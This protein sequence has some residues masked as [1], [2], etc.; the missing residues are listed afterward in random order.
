MIAAVFDTEN[1]GL[2]ANTGRKLDKQPRLFEFY[3]NLITD[4]GDVA[5]ELHFLCHPGIPLPAEVVRITGVTD[6]DLAEQQPFADY[7]AQLQEFFEKADAVVAHNLSYDFFIIEFEYQRLGRSFTWPQIKLCTVE[8]TEYLYGYRLSLQ[9]LHQHLF[10]QGFAG[11]HRA[12]ADVA[13]LNRC[14]I[15][16]VKQGII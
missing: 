7:A 5:E 13:A 3:G 15:A 16:L 4:A 11:A 8:A 9:S 6:R 10:R 1:T 2:I 12:A 14:Y